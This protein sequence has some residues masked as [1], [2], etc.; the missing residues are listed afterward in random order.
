MPNTSTDPGVVGRPLDGVRVL[1]LEQMQA[2]PFATQLLARLGADVIKVELPGRGDSGR[3]SRPAAVVRPGA[4]PVGATFLRNNLGKRSVA[5]DFRT[6]RGRD[7]VA[8]LARRVDV[9]CENLGPGR[10]ERYR[11]GYPA[12]NEVNPAL[13]Y[14]SISGFGTADASPY[15]DWPAYGVV[16]EAMTGMYEYARLPHQPPTVNP[17]GGIGDTGTALYGIVA[18][19]AALR[20]RDR[21]GQGQYIDLAMYD[22]MISMLDLSYNFASLG[23][24]FD[25]EQ[26]RR[27]PL[28]LDSF[29]AADGWVVIQ[30][31]RPHQVERLATMLGRPDWLTDPSFA[32][33]G[34]VDAFPTDVR[35]ALEAWARDLPMLDAGRRLAAAGIPAG[36]C[37]RGE[38]VAGDEHV[39]LHDMVVSLPR[40]D[41]VA[42]PVQVAGNPVRMSK[43]TAGPERP[44]PRLGEHTDEVLH[45][46][47]ALD[48]DDLAGLRRDGVIAT[49]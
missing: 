1:A 29:R 36:P 28:I 34:W 11:L 44:M 6:E 41:G 10:A 7:L 21:I 5:I 31:A 48:E 19:L 13:I 43:V 9:C 30:V 20:H 8:E 2:L 26:E 40:F 46:L 22:A 25:A 12:L 24:C 39:R 18:V 16:V 35:P 37:Y 23:L 27:L 15:R 42:E 47:L 14:L 33:M 4:E 45:E 49:P 3:W 17:L 32:E 38:Q